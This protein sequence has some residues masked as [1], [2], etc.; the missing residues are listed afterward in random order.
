MPFLLIVICSMLVERAAASFDRSVTN[1]KAN[2]IA[3]VPKHFLTFRTTA[4]LEVVAKSRLKGLN[5]LH[6][7]IPQRKYVRGLS[8]AG[9]HVDPTGA[10]RC[11]D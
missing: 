9:I 2:T 5:G 11:D 8:R 7:T 10:A 3:S 1:A 4:L 6:G